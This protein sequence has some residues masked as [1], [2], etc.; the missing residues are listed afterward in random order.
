MACVSGGAAQTPSP[1]ASSTA[2]ER[3]LLLEGAQADNPWAILPH[4]TNYILLFTLAS[5]IEG[6]PTIDGGT[7]VDLDSVESKFQLS[8]KYPLGRGMIFGRGTLFFGYTQLAFWQVWNASESQ[9]FRETVYEPELFMTFQTAVPYWLGLNV[10]LLTIGIAHQ[11]NGR[12]GERFSR[13]WDRIYGSAVFDVG[14]F[15]LG[16]RPWFVIPGTDD[17]N[18]DIEAYMGYGELRASYGFGNHVFTVMTRNNLRFSG[19]RGAIELDYSFPITKRVKGYLQ[20]FS[21]YGESLIDYN[22]PVDRVGFGFLL[23]DWI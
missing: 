1:A 14:N 2:L 7:E 13:G 11:S 6:T 16:I 8:F 5:N 18:P 4:R 10:R 15:V 19:N 20:Y 21:G 3:R 12:G 23:A 9:P 17:D 22:R